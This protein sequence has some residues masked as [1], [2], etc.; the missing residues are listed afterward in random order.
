MLDIEKEYREQ[1]NVNKKLQDE[2][3][4]LKIQVQEAEKIIVFMKLLETNLG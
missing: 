2:I 1:V 3:E 4:D